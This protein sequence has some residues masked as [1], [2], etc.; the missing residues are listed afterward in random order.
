[1]LTAS[2]PIGATV[3]D[4]G[5]YTLVT[6]WSYD[7]ICRSCVAVN[8]TNHNFMTEKSWHFIYFQTKKDIVTIGNSG[9]KPAKEKMLMEA[10]GNQ[11]EDL[12]TY[13]QIILLQLCLIWIFIN[14]NIIWYLWFLF[15]SF[16]PLVPGVTKRSHILKQTSSWNHILKQTCSSKLQ[17]C[18]SM[19]NLFVST[20]Y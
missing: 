1:M 4:L 3:T 14:I 16:N 7:I 2:E 5:K 10:S 11:K 8:C 12:F 17:F 6:L 20:R 19:C 15:W 13:A 18:L 9:F